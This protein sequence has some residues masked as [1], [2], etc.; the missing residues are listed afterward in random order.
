MNKKM[1]KLKGVK[2][3]LLVVCS[4]VMVLVIIGNATSSF[5][6]S[7]TNLTVSAAVSL[8]DALAEIQTLYTKS[9]KD[10]NFAF[11]FGSSGSLQQQIEQGAPVDI[12]ISA[13]QTQIDN[14]KKKNLLEESTIK[15]IIGNKLVLVVPRDYNFKVT[16]DNLTSKK[17][18]KIAIGT[19]KSVPAGDYATQVLTKLG[20]INKIKSKLVYAKDVREVLSWVEMGNADTGFVYMSDALTSN[21]VKIVSVTDTKNG[22][23]LH[24]PI[25]Y[26]AAVVKGTKNLEASKAF[27]NFLDTKEAKNIFVKY[28]FSPTNTKK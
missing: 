3:G 9:N 7:D 14:L 25:Q 6:L 26:I 28:G 13:G 27:I 15:S 12:F 20:I 22:V 19:P 4:I 23:Q 11:N 17:V 2:R 1:K 10:V 5:A 16:L 18:K 21:K 8:K 24:K